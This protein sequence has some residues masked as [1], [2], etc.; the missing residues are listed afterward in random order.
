MIA[1][2]DTFG[3]E[4]GSLGV[5]GVVDVFFALSAKQVAECR[6]NNH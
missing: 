5:C 4:M 3:G 1:L 6:F 2:L